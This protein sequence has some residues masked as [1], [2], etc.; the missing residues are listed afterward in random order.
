[1]AES[2]QCFALLSCRQSHQRNRSQWQ[3]EAVLHVSHLTAGPAAPTQ[4]KPN[5]LRTN[6]PSDTML[7]TVPK[8]VAPLRSACSDSRARRIGGCLWESPVC[9][10]APGRQQN[11]D[12]LRHRPWVPLQRF[13]IIVKKPPT[14]ETMSITNK[15]DE[16]N[17]EGAGKRAGRG[18]KEGERGGRWVQWRCLWGMNE[19]GSGF[20]VR[21]A[22]ASAKQPLHRQ[23]TA[24]FSGHTCRIPPLG[25][26]RTRSIG[27]HDALSGTRPRYF[28][29]TTAQRS[30]D[31]GDW[32]YSIGA[33]EGRTKTEAWH[34][35]PTKNGPSSLP[36]NSQRHRTRSSKTI[37][38]AA[39]P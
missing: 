19:L 31:L 28:S 34:P 8:D 10:I 7:S 35:S 2:I 1:M 20:W 9:S 32:K 24:G 11:S 5:P 18:G 13:L 39:V 30:I 38:T 14:T 12:H 6:S 16:G 27:F 29:T 4:D 22:A 26:Y 15:A 23:P 17:N 25:A 36:T 37:S 33:S 21:P 3:N